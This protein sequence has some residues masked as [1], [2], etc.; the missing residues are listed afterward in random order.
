[1]GLDGLQVV[2]RDAGR[3]SSCAAARRSRYDECC[4]VSVGGRE[5]GG[6]ER[7]REKKEREERERRERER[8]REER[9]R[10]RERERS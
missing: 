9:E 8:E 4:Y 7:K 1:M 3:G 2:G 6:R 5:G 10:E